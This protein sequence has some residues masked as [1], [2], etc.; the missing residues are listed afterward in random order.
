[1][2][3]YAARRG[4]R[5]TGVTLSRDQKAHVDA[6]IAREELP[7]EVKYQDFFTF[8]P[9]VRFDAVSMMGVIEDL[10]DYRRVMR[11][12]SGLVKPG[13]RVYLDFGAVDRADL[14]GER[15]HLLRAV[16]GERA[17]QVFLVR[18]V[19]VEGAVRGPGGA[20]DVV[21]AALVVAA[22]GEH[23]HP[24]VGETAHRLAA[25][26]PQL[27]LARRSACGGAWAPSGVV[28]S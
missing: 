9:G 3:R 24:R 11:R 20:D 18:E 16:G 25:L 4:V 21:H 8:E 5:V 28:R 15:V 6:L 13:R 12:L 23:P 27:A 17:Q 19:E 26:R 22:L 2:L 14:L 1:M 10:S 7:A